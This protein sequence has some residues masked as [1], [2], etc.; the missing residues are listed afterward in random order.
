[1]NDGAYLPWMISFC[2]T[3]LFLITFLVKQS[4]NSELHLSKFIFVFA[5][6]T[7]LF[8]LF[9][10]LFGLTYSIC[11]GKKQM[12]KQLKI[13]V[14]TIVLDFLTKKCYIIFS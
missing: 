9:F 1:M 10:C 3:K 5:A 12:F 14:V 7:L 4:E 13:T 6:V 11:F 8:L 2:E